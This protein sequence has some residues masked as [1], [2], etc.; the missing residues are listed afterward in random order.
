MTPNHVTRMSRLA[1]RFLVLICFFTASAALAQTSDDESANAANV[2]P[3]TI[4]LGPRWEEGQT[5]RYEFWNRMQQTAE[6]RLGDRTQNSSNLIEVEGEITWTVDRVKPD[7]SAL[8]TMTLDWM[9]YASTPNEGPSLAVDSR[10]SPQTEETKPM[11]E[12]LSAMAGVEL[13][14]EVAAD[15]HVTRVKGLEK[16]KAKTSQPDFIPSELDFEETATELASIA[17]APPPFSSEAAAGQK[18]NADYRWEHELGKVDQR[19]A[20]E[21]KSVEDI[22]G[23]P[24]AIVTGKGEFKLD[25]EEPEDAPPGS[26]P[27]D[28]RMLEGVAESEVLFDLARHEAVGRH[29]TSREKIEVAVTFPDGRRFVRTQTEEMTGQMLRLAED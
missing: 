21:V 29:S 1:R 27:I 19:W 4:D 12:L 28:V 3:A 17:F 11:H 20:Y 10:R 2:I 25:P 8:G 16:M 13:T 6:A 5:A 7:G 14:I 9:T 23:V 22:A 26:P 15:G 24:V 18:W